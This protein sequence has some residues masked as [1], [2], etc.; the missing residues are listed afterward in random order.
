MRGRLVS[1]EVSNNG[2]DFTS[3]GHEFLYMEDIQALN[4]SRREG[5]S[6]GGGTPVILSGENFGKPLIYIRSPL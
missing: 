3:G 4:M 1:F 5:P 6:N 2:Q